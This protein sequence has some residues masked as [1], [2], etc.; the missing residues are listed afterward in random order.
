VLFDEDS[1]PVFIDPHAKVGSPAFDWAFW[2]VYYVPTSGFV[3]RV[4]LCREYAP[5]ELDEALAWSVTLAVDGALYYLDTGDDRVAAML[6]VLESEPLRRF[7]FA[8]DLT[9]PA[10]RDS[11]DES[12]EWDTCRHGWSKRM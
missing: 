1:G 8:P 10:T 7:T 9:R 4:A 5:A 2:C 12:G 11:P 3:D 6:T